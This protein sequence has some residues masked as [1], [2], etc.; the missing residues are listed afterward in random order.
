MSKRKIFGI[1]I[2]VL[3]VVMALL[4]NVIA[5]VCNVLNKMGMP[6]RCMYTGHIEVA[7]GA[8]IVVIGL[9]IILSKDSK[10]A[11][12]AAIP[13]L[14]LGTIPWLSAVKLIG[15]C[16]SP[17]MGC[18]MYNK[19]AVILVTGLIELIFVIYLILELKNVKNSQA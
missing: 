13:G 19:P 4:P 16:K 10:I 8:V 1:I 17:K 2:A 7:V 6:M 5:P 18:L 14:F 9:V 3:G 12:G 15:M 11:Y